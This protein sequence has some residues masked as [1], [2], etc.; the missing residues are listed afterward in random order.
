[1]H[2]RTLAEYDFLKHVQ[3]FFYKTDMSST[4][5]ISIYENLLLCARDTPTAAV[6]DVYSIMLIPILNQ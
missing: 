1:M 2:R 5:D 3:H 6:R 4:G